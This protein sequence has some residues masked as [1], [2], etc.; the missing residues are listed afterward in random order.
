M[1]TETDRKTEKDRGRV[2]KDTETDRDREKKKKTN[3][4]I[5][6]SASVWSRITLPLELTRHGL[7][8]LCFIIKIAIRELKTV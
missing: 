4:E 1:E 3:R 6:P 8:I 5:E 2:S 7:L